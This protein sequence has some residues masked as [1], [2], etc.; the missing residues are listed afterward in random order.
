MRDPQFADGASIKRD[1]GG[2]LKKGSPRVV[3]GKFLGALKKPGSEGVEFQ[4]IEI[5]RKR[6]RGENRKE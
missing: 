4:G 3:K 5:C 6:K 2:L 1:V